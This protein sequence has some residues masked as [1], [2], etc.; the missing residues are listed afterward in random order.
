ME[1]K[2]LMD[3][4][5]L[6]EED[7]HEGLQEIKTEITKRMRVKLLG[8]LIISMLGFSY[9]VLAR[10]AGV[11]VPIFMVIQFVCLSFLMPKK[12]PLLMFIPMFVL[13]LNSFI[14]AN[15]IWRIPNFLVTI[16]LFSIMGLWLVGDFSIKGKLA[17]FIYKIIENIFK[18]FMHFPIPLSWCSEINKERS[19]TIKR[20][21]LGIGISIPLLLFIL[22]MLAAADEIFLHSV[23]DF[24]RTIL[25]LIRI[26]RIFRI[27]LGV[28]AGFYL[29]GI[30]Y[31]VHTYKPKQGV[32]T[33]KNSINGDLI[34]I[35]IVLGSILTIYTVFVAI[36]FRYLFAGADNLPYGLNYVEYAR[37]GFFE[38]LFLT[39]VNIAI[40]L[41]AVWLTKEQKSKGAKFS[42]ALCGYLCVV[43]MILLVS[44]FYRMW[45]YSSEYG[46]TRLR[47]LVFGFLAFEAIGLVFTLFYIKK[48]KFN[49]IAVY[50]VIA[51][52]YYL[53]LNI[54]PMDWVVARNQVDRYFASES[55]G[56]TY[57]LTLSADAAGQIARLNE[58]NNQETHLRI[59]A[60][61]DRLHLSEGGWRQ[62][63]L[64]TNRAQRY[65]DQQ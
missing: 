1:Q 21:L 39:G 25:T 59:A 30:T 18:P 26:D 20:V 29:F 8:Y 23:A 65:G 48:P 52:T 22:V 24:S 17:G 58:S 56:I 45:L 11:S 49:I 9:L 35:N 12:K 27:K 62:W 15:S 63:N 2:C 55:G 37:R 14:S 5:A 40:I 3:S 6:L 43:T 44:S 7:S 33:Y 36:Q 53:M 57:L 41:I 32:S 19:T 64:S 61:Y 28:V 54:V 31:L 47:F 10:H 38:L 50:S 13:S 60:Y 34:V 42:K 4:H 46:L 51:L 16:I